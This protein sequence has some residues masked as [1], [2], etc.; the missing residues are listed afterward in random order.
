[1]SDE[2]EY[3]FLICRSGDDDP[4][5]VGRVAFPWVFDSEQIGFLSYWVTPEHQGN[6]YVTEATELFLDYAFRERGFHKLDAHVNE[7][8]AASAAVLEKLGFERE[9][10][11]RQESF[12]DGDWEDSL[13]YGLLAEEWLDR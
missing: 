6:G 7:S 3:R 13:S 4:E 5:P 9:G 2:D 8:N 1:M 12:V 10:V 11:R